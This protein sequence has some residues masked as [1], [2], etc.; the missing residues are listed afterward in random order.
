MIRK[1][2]FRSDTIPTW[3]WLWTLNV[4]FFMCSCLFTEHSSC[5]LRIDQS[6][7]TLDDALNN[8]PSMVSKKNLWV[9][10]FYPHFQQYFSYIGGEITE[11]HQPVTSHWQNVVLNTPPHVIEL[12]TGDRPWL[13]SKSTS[14]VPYDHAM[15]D[16]DN[17]FLDHISTLYTM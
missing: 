15:M 17:W 6:C 13:H 5:L 3:S 16:P 14:E 8:D 7:W 1:Q 9:T 12:T 4:W 11:N 10:G 2:L